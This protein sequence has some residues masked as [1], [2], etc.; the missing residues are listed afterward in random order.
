MPGWH[1]KTREYVED[2]R[3]LVLGIAPEQHGDRMA[4]FLQWKEM[5]DMIVMVDSYNVLGLKSVPLTLLIDESGVIRHR[6]PSSEVLHQFLAA[7][8]ADHLAIHD[9]YESVDSVWLSPQAAIADFREI[10]GRGVA[11]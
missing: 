10:G 9:G 4:L 3:L 11:P 1:A 8:P 2:G 6:N 7:A 5:E